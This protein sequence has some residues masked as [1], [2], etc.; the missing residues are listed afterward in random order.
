[1]VGIRRPPCQGGAGCRKRCPVPRS[2]FCPA[3][4]LDAG[5]VDPQLVAPYSFGHCAMSL[6]YI[7]YLDK[8]RS[9][10][11]TSPALS[12]YYIRQSSIDQTHS[13]TREGDDPRDDAVDL[14]APAPTRLERISKCNA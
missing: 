6:C 12:M 3:T 5:T 11:A 1:M 10:L 7:G 8:T 9:R 4:V 14:S 2:C 13:I